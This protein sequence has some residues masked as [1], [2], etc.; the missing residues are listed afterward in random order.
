ME[1]KILFNPKNHMARSYRQLRA[2][3]FV[4]IPGGG[5]TTLLDFW[6]IALSSNTPRGTV[7]KADMSAIIDWLI[8]H[9]SQH[10]I[11]QELYHAQNDRTGGNLM[12]A[13]MVTS[14]LTH[15]LDIW[16]NRFENAKQLLL[17]GYP[18]YDSQAKVMEDFESFGINHLDVHR[19]VAWRSY[20]KRWRETPVHK[21]RPDDPT[22]E[23]ELQHIFDRREHSYLA[24]TLPIVDRRRDRTFVSHREIN[25][26]QRV[27]MGLKAFSAM[28]DP[29]VH[30]DLVANA[31]S[32]IGNTDSVFHVEALK[33]EQPGR[34]CENRLVLDAPAPAFAPSPA[35]AMA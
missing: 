33:I 17:S 12:D 28:E 18:R 6:H 26:A 5:K 14:A 15:W 9:R 23:I 8:A 32:I 20:H 22:S 2:V 1:T 35:G 13:D 31:L 19:E 16:V 25:L 21:R 34:F 24:K 29:P 30:S 27:Y 7:I 10:K 4:A 3:C 11:G